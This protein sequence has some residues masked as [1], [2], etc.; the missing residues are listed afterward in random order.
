MTELEKILPG[1]LYRCGDKELMSLWN[2][3][4]N[5]MQCYNQLV[6][7]DKTAQNAIL[8]DLLGCHGAGSVVTHDIPS[9]SLAYGNPYRV[10]K[11]IN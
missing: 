1:D 7:D 4:K 11:E 2:K 6:Y 9:H 3:G 5:L 10:I 8:D